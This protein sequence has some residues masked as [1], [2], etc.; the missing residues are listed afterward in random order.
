MMDIARKVVTA[1]GEDAVTADVISRAI[2]KFMPSSDALATKT[3]ADCRDRLRLV[4]NEAII[5]LDVTC[6]LITCNAM[7]CPP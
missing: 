5:P 1:T 7:L 3:A 2:D 6:I 4:R